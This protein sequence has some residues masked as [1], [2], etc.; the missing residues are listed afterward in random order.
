MKRLTKSSRYA[1]A[2]RLDK[3][4]E[5]RDQT[6]A[7]REISWT[8]LPAKKN[9]ASAPTGRKIR[10]NPRALNQ[11]LRLSEDHPHGPENGNGTDRPHPHPPTHLVSDRIGLRKEVD[12]RRTKLRESLAQHRIHDAQLGLPPRTINVQQPTAGGRRSQ[13]ISNVQGMGVRAP[14]SSFGNW[15]FPVGYWT[16]VEIA[17]GELASSVARPK[18]VFRSFG[19][20]LESSTPFVV[21]YRPRGPRR[22]RSRYRTTRPETEPPIS[23]STSPRVE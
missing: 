13:R 12:G 2:L 21:P 22:K 5:A 19:G 16:F 1:I 10:N 3:C 14:L 15:T 18:Q 7:L 23:A 17:F 4:E 20:N 6:E 9:R 8:C 11:A